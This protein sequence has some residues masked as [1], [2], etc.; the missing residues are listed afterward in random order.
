MQTNTVEHLLVRVAE[1]QSQLDRLT[2]TRPAFTPGD[3]VTFTFGI[4]DEL[5]AT[6][7][8]LTTDRQG[9]PA[10]VLAVAGHGL[11]WHVEPLANLRRVCGHC[12][13]CR[14]LNQRPRCAA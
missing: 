8:R 3:R 7:D 5:Y 12:A 10:A 13:D 11:F 6:V 1:L 14:A 4:S 9:E 2:T